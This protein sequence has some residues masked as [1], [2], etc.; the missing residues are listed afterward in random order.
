[1]RSALYKD[2]FTVALPVATWTAGR[3]GKGRLIASAAYVGGQSRREGE[4]AALN[5]KI[6]SR[7]DALGAHFALDKGS[8]PVPVSNES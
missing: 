2:H 8:D 5:L 1:M 4:R 3:V 7:A 6:D